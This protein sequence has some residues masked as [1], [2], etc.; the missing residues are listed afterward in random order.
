M[1]HGVSRER[2]R[3]LVLMGVT[4]AGIVSGVS[5]GGKRMMREP[6][7]VEKGASCEARPGRD[8]LSSS[9]RMR[10][11]IPTKMDAQETERKWDNKNCCSA[12]ASKIGRSRPRRASS[13]AEKP[14]DESRRK[15]IST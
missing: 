14:K 11:M 7:M 15:E 4:R 5:N 9:M 2:C 10:T 12:Q 8:E 3:I 1:R 6:S 13:R